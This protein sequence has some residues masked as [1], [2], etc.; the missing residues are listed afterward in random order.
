MCPQQ[1][2][3]EYV[4]GWR[5]SSGI[6]ADKGTI[7]HKVLEVMAL[8]KKAEQDNLKSFED[9]VVGNFPC[10]GYDID[11]LTEEIYK[12][13]SDA[14]PQHNWSDKDLR[15]CKKWAWKALEFNDGMFDPRKRKIVDAEPHFDFVID[16]PWADYNTR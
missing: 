11:K 3:C 13:Y 4:L 15:D 5:G 12:Y 8:A 10:D 2:F 6:K 1:Y 16:E 9:D 14:S 7:V